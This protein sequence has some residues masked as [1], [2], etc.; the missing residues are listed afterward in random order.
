MS[1]IIGLLTVILAMNCLFLILLILIQLPKKEAGMGTA[2]GGAATDALFGA[3]SGNALTKVTR[4]AA[5][6]FFALSLFLSITNASRSGRSRSHLDELL[7]KQAAAGA[8]ATPSKSGTNGASGAK[9]AA[10]ANLLPGLTNIS[11]STP[12]ATN[13]AAPTKMLEATNLP[14]VLTNAPAPRAK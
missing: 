6:L 13:I 4:Y 3:G 8:L 12:S 14:R 11:L 10:A 5:T 9:S 1:F 7:K 2:F